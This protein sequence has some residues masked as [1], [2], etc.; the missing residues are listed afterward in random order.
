MFANPPPPPEFL[1]FD[2]LLKNKN[3]E[4][5]GTLLMKNIAMDSVHSKVMSQ[6]VLKNY[7]MQ[8]SKSCSK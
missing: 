3:V 5:L 8:V 1:L 2:L 4:V 6:P 7:K